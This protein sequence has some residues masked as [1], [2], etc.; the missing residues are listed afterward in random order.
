MKYILFLLLLAALGCSKSG[1]SY[2]YSNGF[3]SIDS[4]SRFDSGFVFK[5]KVSGYLKLNHL[6]LIRDD[7]NTCV[8]D[9]DSPK[10]ST[11]YAY[12]TT[13]T[14]SPKDT[15]LYHFIGYYNNRTDVIIQPSFKA[16]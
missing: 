9:V 7:E 6:Y 2:N 11:Y 14:R 5:V 12:D 10:D 16:R 13:L 8:W 15:L 1:P 4:V 3:V